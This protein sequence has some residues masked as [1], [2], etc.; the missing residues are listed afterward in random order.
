ML[1][2]KQHQVHS[3]LQRHDET[4]HLRFRQC[5]RSP[6]TDLV[7]P[8]RNHATARTHHIAIARAADSCV[9]A[10]ARLRHGNLF[11]NRLRDT[12]CINWVGSLVRR[13]TNHAL[14]MILNG[15]RQHVVRTYHIRSHSLHREELA[16][17]HLLQCCSMEDIVYARHCRPTRLQRA[18]VTDIKLDFPCH[19]RIL[20]LILMSHIILLLLV[21]AE[22]TNLLNIRIQETLQHGISKRPCASRNQK[23]FIFEYTHLFM[24]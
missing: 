7:N 22:D 20:H 11:L 24:I 23:D 8:Q 4:C 6:F 12:H 18:H 16:R 14:H 5:D 15:C 9:T 21:T 10:I 17:R 13:Q 3:L 2:G 1:K 19:L